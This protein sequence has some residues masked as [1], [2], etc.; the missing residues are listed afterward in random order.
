VTRK[1]AIANLI[2]AWSQRDQDF[3]VGMSESKQSD[4][5]MRESLRA[6]G[7]SDEEMEAE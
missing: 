1:E 6:I 3:C 2:V 5:K 7:V 4:D